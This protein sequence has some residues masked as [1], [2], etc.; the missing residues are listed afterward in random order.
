MRIYKLV[1]CDIL[2][3]IFVKVSIEYIIMLNLHIFIGLYYAFTIIGT[4]L[5]MSEVVR[6]HILLVVMHKNFLLKDFV[7]SLFKPRKDVTGARTVGQS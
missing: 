2:A 7:E 3:P 4:F 1:T 5:E 6:P